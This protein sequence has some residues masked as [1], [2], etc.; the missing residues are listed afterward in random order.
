MNGGRIG[1]NTASR[2][3]GVSVNSAG[4]FTKADTGGVILQNTATG[5]A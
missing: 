4:L 3:G 1:N 5:Q 2:G